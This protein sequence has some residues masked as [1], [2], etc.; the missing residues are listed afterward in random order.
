MLADELERPWH[1]EVL[2][3]TALVLLAAIASQRVKCARTYSGVLAVERGDEVGKGCLVDEVIEDAD[4]STT[5]DG[6]RMLEPAS[7]RWQHRWS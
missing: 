7:K 4:A 3:R 1:P 6:L 5:H 2:A